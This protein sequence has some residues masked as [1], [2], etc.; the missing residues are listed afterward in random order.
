MRDGCV[1]DNGNM[2]WVAQVL[3]LVTHY[4]ESDLA[5]YNDS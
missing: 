3:L 1:T 2:L 5:T 4:D